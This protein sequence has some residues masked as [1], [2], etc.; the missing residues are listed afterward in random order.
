MFLPKYQR[1]IFTPI[2][3]NRQNYSFVYS[4]FYVFRQQ[5][6][7]QKGLGSMTASITHIQSPLNFILNQVLICYFL[8]Y[9]NCATFLKDLLT[10][11][12][13]WFCLAFWW[14]DININLVISAFTSSTTSLLASVRVSVFLYGIFVIH[15]IHS[16]YHF[17][18]NKRKYFIKY[19]TSNRSIRTFSVFNFVPPSFTRQGQ[20]TYEYVRSCLLFSSTFRNVKLFIS[21]FRGVKPSLSSNENDLMTW[22]MLISSNLEQ[23]V[24]LWLTDKQQNSPNT[25]RIEGRDTFRNW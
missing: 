18:E 1:P 9:L 14:W 24:L 12:M 20:P 13:L 19:F 5:T 6:R 16:R 25:P 8:K 22:S 15:I 11:F 21:A 23:R 10:I 2:Q 7:R 4:N 3:Q 17:Y